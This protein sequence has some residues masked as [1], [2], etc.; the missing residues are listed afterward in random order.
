MKSRQT[1]VGV[2][3]QLLPFAAL[4]LLFAAVGV[5]HVTSRVMV[6]DAGYR[7]SKLE[8]DGRQLAVENQQLKL[9]LAT[10][11]SPAR[12]EKI[13]REQ[14]NMAPPP[15]GGVIALGDQ[16]VAGHPERTEAESN[17]PKTARAL[18]ATVAHRPEE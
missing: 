12:L 8:G 2:L 6:V 15:P 7:L 17:H 16:R 3:K 13:A 4:A 1:L 14:L 10:L 5:M 11:K 18:L 9:E